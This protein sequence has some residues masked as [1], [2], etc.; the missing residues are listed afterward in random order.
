[1]AV[2]GH[3]AAST[4]NQSLSALLFLYR[5]VLEKDFGW[6]EDVVRANK[7]KHLP[8]VFTLEEV[9]SILGQ[10]SGRRWLMAMQVYG[11][12][13]RLNECLSLR[14]KDLDFERLQVV[15]RDAKGQKDRVTLLPQV[16]VEPLKQHLV[17]VRE[18]H[19][20]ALREGYAGV[21]LPY[22]LAEK[23]PHAD[24]EWGWQYVYPAV[25]RP[26]QRGS[27][28]P[29]PG[30][31]VPAKG[32]TRRASEV[33]DQEARRVPHVQTQFRHA[34]AGHGDRYPDGPGAVGA[35][36]REHDADLHP[37]VEVERLCRAEPGRQ[38]HGAPLAASGDRETQR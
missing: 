8:E 36:G 27:A 38:A 29:S 31:V 6:L 11:G 32:R 34:L 21:A 4:Q 20:L 2:E 14:V 28:A 3:V 7:P 9:E 12:G 5:E 37:R 24:R 15:V 13:L 1:L 19:E 17:R 33:G 16:V 25:A 22:A 10:L 26:A 30:R 23:Y 18:A 35:Q